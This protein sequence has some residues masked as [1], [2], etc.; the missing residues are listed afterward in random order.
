MTILPKIFFDKTI[1]FL[2]KNLRFLFVCFVFLLAFFYHYFIIPPEASKGSKVSKEKVQIVQPDLDVKRPEKIYPHILQSQ[3]GDVFRIGVFVS[4]KNAENIEIFAESGLNEVLKIGEWNLEPSENGEYKELFFSAPGRY[5]N[6][7]IRLQKN[8]ERDTAVS[9]QNKTTIH[10]KWDDSAVYIR[11]F[12][13]SRVEIGD[14]SES[15]NL[16][17]TVFGISSLKRDVLLREEDASKDAKEQNNLT[18]WVFQSSGDFLQALEFSGKKVGSGRQE[19]VFSLRRYFPD[20]KEKEGELLHTAAFV[21][22]A[23]DD[24]LVATGNYRMQFPFPLIQGEWYKVTFIKTPSKDRDNFFTIGPLETDIEDDSDAPAGD[25]TLLTGERLRTK[26][27][28]SF[29][30]GAKLEDL[31]KNLSYSFS[32]QGTPLDFTN[33]FDARG[34]ITYDAK[35][36]LVTGGQKN[37]EYFIYKFDLPYPFDRF[38]LEAMEESNDEKEIKLEYSFD[39]AFWRE[40]AFTQEKGDPQKFLLTLLGDG[41]SRTVYVRVSYNGAEKKSG[42]FALKTLNVTASIGKTR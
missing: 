3:A 25:L 28:A 8:E 23:L 21:L 40:I 15:H 17:P 9:E 5:E 24:L 10:K 35:K 22:D 14:I 27:D 29:P 18:E 11:S 7:I 12:F 32:L 31:G 13:V 16:A 26:N 41:K 34:S 2:R 42:F 30:D 37:R 36:H 6:I 1:S 39:N 20:K 33:I 38:V 19:Y 4:T